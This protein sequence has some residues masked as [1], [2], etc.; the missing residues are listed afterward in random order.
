MHGPS[1][2]RRGRQQT[3]RSGRTGC[4]WRPRS[5]SAGSIAICVCSSAGPARRGWVD[6]ATALARL[7]AD[8]GHLKHPERAACYALDKLGSSAFVMRT[9][10]PRT[11]AVVLRFENEY[12]VFTAWTGK[13]WVGGPRDPVAVPVAVAVR[14]TPRQLRYAIVMQIRNDREDRPRPTSRLARREMTGASKQTQR[15]AEQKLA[16]SVRENY[17]LLPPGAALT[18]RR[19]VRIRALGC[20]AYQISN[21]TDVPFASSPLASTAPPNGTVPG[22]P[23]IPRPGRVYPDETD[24]FAYAQALGQ[25]VDGYVFVGYFLHNERLVGLWRAAGDGKNRSSLTKP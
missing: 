8:F 5:G 1:S 6:E 25:P 13:H 3:S 22:M 15:R 10:D 17:C 7:A 21:S 12:R 11:G 19:P 14:L 24:A 23:A 9:V 16:L 2:I 20:L 4:G 18:G